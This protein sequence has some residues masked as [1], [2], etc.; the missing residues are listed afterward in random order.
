[1]KDVTVGETCEL[2]VNV[3]YDNGIRIA[4]KTQLL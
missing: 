4:W 3:Y 2:Q 1:M